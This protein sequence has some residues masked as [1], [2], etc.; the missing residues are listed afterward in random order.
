M[1]G[2]SKQF[3]VLVV[4]DLFIDIVMSGFTELPAPG[5]E[6]FA[7][8]MIREAGG[9][10]SI[11]ASGLARLGAKTGV[12]GVVDDVDGV[13]LAQRLKSVGVDTG[14]LQRHPTEPTG[15]TV[16][17]SSDRDRSFFTYTGANVGLPELLD[18]HDIRATLQQAHHVHFACCLNPLQLK[19]LTD[20]LHEAETCVS[21][22]VGW[23]PD[24]LRSEKSIRAIC[25][26]DL[27]LPNESEAGLMTQ[28]KT[29]DAILD[30]FD[31]MGVRQLALKMGEKGSALMVNGRKV[32]SEAL[33]V[34][35]VDTTGAGD[36]FDAGFIYGMLRGEPPERCLEIGNISG[37]LSTRALGGITAFPSPAEIF[38]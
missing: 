36:S 6:A 13:W 29:P 5:H 18:R 7:K 32:F 33:K 21:L 9:G 25:E 23:H 17:I 10:A 28:M 12:I 2:H 15:L 3:E 19:E 31:Q 11:T 4:G 26:L 8:T 22:D 30:A 34:N 35:V 1:S 16:A 38:Q 37:A 14:M 27:F 24:W 20:L